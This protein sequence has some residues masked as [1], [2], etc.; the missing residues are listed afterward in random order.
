MAA[1]LTEI[2][3]LPRAREQSPCRNSERMQVVGFQRKPALAN[4]LGANER[5]DKNGKEKN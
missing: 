2:V 3:S 5:S 1:Y 4:M